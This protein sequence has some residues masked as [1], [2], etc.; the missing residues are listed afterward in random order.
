MKKAF[1]YAW[2][3]FTLG[4]LGFHSVYFEKLSEVRARAGKDFDFEAFADSLYYR[5]MLTNEDQLELSDLLAAIQANA[6]DAFERY[7]NR[8]GIGNSA[9]FMVRCRGEVTEIGPDAIRLSSPETGAVS[10]NT[11]YIFGNA[12]RD[13]SGLVSLTDFKTNAA[14]NRVSEALNTLIR[15]EVIPPIV[16][17]LTPGDSIAVTGAIKLSKK[18][19][20][21]PEL[22]ITP[23][24]IQPQ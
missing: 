21:D 2:L 3:V 24:K 11:R 6:Q 17:E 8:L 13:A 9:Y 14:F 5:G 4:F 15:T 18:D 12:L 23:V 7:G 16:E 22:I 19:L 10:I 1:Q 20:N